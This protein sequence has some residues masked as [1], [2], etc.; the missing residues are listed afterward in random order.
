MRVMGEGEG[1]GVGAMGED[2]GE[3]EGRRLRCLKSAE[4]CQTMITN[5]GRAQG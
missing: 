4:T 2:E 5:Q 3:G 1:E